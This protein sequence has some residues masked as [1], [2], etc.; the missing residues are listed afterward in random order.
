MGPKKGKK[1]KKNQDDDWG[2]ADEEKKLEEKMKSLRQR[3]GAGSN[4]NNVNRALPKVGIQYSI[5][6]F[7]KMLQ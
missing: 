5:L 6:V 1:G 4:S 2:D 3:T 7:F